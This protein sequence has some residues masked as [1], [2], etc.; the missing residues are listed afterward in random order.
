MDYMHPANIHG[1]PT[2]PGAG[3]TMVN[4][5]HMIPALMEPTFRGENSS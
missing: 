1:V 4:Q 2:L 3:T 5:M